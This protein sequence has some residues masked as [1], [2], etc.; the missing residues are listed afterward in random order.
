MTYREM[1][2][3]TET[4][5]QGLDFRVPPTFPRLRVLGQGFRLGTAPPPHCN[6]WMVC[7]IAL[8]TTPEVLDCD[9]VGA[10]PKV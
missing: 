5:M 8:N 7:I 1:R 9:R 10:V 6:S 2:K 3:K 4:P